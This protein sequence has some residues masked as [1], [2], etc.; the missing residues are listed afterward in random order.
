[1]KIPIPALLRRLRNEH[2]RPSGAVAGGPT[3]QGI[4]VERAVWKGWELVNRLPALNDIQSRLL[5]VLGDRLPGV[6]PLRHWT[7]SRDLPPFAKK[8]LTRWV[9]E[10]GIYDA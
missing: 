4:P 7:Q 5:G 8:R 2:A 3:G 10:E 6:G 9:G 1:V